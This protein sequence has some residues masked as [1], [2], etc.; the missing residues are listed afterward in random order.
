M[1]R[2]SKNAGS[3]NRVAADLALL[4]LFLA[5]VT[6]RAQWITQPDN[7]I[8]YNGGKVGVGTNDP[9]RGLHVIGGLLLSSSE[10]DNVGKSTT[11]E[12]WHY[13]LSEKPVLY[14]WG[15]S[16]ATDT[17]LRIGA[18]HTSFNTPTRIEFYTAPTTTTT[19]VIRMKIAPTGNVGIGTTNPGEKLDVAGNI[20]LSGDIVS[21][22]SD[23]QIRN[24]ATGS[25]VKLLSNG[26]VCIGSGCP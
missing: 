5:P 19:G 2:D 17:Y 11:V 14:L 26:D 3:L 7:D 8:Y 4:A 15:I 12:S 13:S 21:A 9:K 6:V 1:S 24:A 16:N 25:A 20:K 18:S 22:D 10:A 23:I